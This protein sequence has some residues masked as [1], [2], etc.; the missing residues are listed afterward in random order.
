MHPTAMD[1]SADGNSLLTVSRGVFRF[2]DIKSRRMVVEFKN[3]SGTTI[4][5]TFWLSPTAILNRTTASGELF[6]LA[7]VVLEPSML[8]NL[9]NFQQITEGNPDFRTGDGR[10]IV[11]RRFDGGTDVWNPDQS[12]RLRIAAPGF[13]RVVDVTPDNQ[14]VVIEGTPAEVRRAVDGAKVCTI[15]TDGKCQLRFSPSGTALVAAHANSTVVF[16]PLSGAELA[17]WPTKMEYSGIGC[18]AFSPD[19]SLLA[20][21][22]SEGEIELRE[23][24]HWKRL[25]LLSTPGPPNQS[26]GLFLIAWTPDSTRIVVFGNG[27]RT[28]DWDIARLSA[29]LAKLGLGWSESK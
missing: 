5:P 17:R 15:K 23:T 12:V 27:S 18:I 21:C 8:P 29:E 11:M 26:S 6:T 16:D 14:L 1:I 19:G 24:R 3:P 10:G 4:G 20:V 7:K 13:G 28:F 2:W 9:A 25:A 22:H